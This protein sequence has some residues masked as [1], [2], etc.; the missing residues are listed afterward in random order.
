MLSSILVDARSAHKEARNIVDV[1]SVFSV[2]RLGHPVDGRVGVEHETAEEAA[3]HH[4]RE[5]VIENHGGPAETEHNLEL[6]CALERGT[7][8]TGANSCG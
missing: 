2:L 6:V 1:D 7:S 8:L 5:D 4:A 3:V